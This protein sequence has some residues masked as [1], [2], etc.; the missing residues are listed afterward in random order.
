MQNSRSA[1]ATTNEPRTHLPEGR[2]QGRQRT[3]PRRS[4]AGPPLGT[5]SSTDAGGARAAAHPGGANARSVASEPPQPSG[6]DP[7]SACRSSPRAAASRSPGNPGGTSGSRSAS[8]RDTS[9]VAIWAW[10][11]RL[12]LGGLFAFL[13]HCDAVCH[14]GSVEIHAM[15]ACKLLFSVLPLLNVPERT[16]RY[17][18]RN[19]PFS[20]RH[21][22]KSQQTLAKPIHYGRVAG[23]TRH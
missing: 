9:R 6:G 16:L 17:G 14:P 1:T 22:L 21:D 15:A 19:P 5:S 18:S 11:I 4:P 7:R 10:P 13:G 2:H 3:R 8:G 20:A 12:A 23:L